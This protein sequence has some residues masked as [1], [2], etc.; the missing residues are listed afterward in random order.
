[1]HNNTLIVVVF[2]WPNIQKYY[3]LFFRNNAWVHFKLS[4]S[5]T[6]PLANFNIQNVIVPP[7]RGSNTLY[8]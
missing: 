1:M 3:W 6:H 8:F 4:H 2:L 7:G 5:K